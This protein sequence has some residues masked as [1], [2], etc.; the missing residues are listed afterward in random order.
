MNVADWDMQ[1]RS[2][3]PYRQER[4]QAKP[5][6]WQCS[7]CRF[8]TRA[9]A[10]AGQDMRLHYRRTGRTHTL[11]AAV[12]GDALIGRLWPKTYPSV[13]CYTQLQAS[14]RITPNV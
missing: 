5:S 8:I 4:P 3:K 6:R 10:A 14:E 1:R 7:D 2:R 12:S 13:L 11:F 9:G